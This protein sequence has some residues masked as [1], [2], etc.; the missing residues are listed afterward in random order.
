MSKPSPQELAVGGLIAK[1]AQQRL[2][3]EKDVLEAFPELEGD[4]E[5]SK[6]I[7][8]ILTDMGWEVVD[9]AEPYIE[10]VT[11]SAEG[12]EELELARPP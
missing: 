8:R 3:T 12:E 4:A 1:G 11:T 6:A 7:H 10:V 2:L 5:R 9:E